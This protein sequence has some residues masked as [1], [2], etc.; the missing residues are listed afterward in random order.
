MAVEMVDRRIR[1]LWNNGGE[2]QSVTHPLELG[3]NTEQ[4]LDDDRWYIIEA[5]R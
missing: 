3:T 2:T 4:L 5:T 1:F